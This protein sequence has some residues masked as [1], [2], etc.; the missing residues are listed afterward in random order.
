[1]RIAAIVSAALALMM[2][3]EAAEPSVSV[4]IES[5]AGLPDPQ[6]AQMLTRR[7]FAGI[8]TGIEWRCSSGSEQAIMIAMST[9][10]PDEDHPGTSAGAC[11][12]P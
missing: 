10:T 4:C 1:L 2:N 7:I 3:G 6:Y 5:G 11:A 8:G 12:G 9:N